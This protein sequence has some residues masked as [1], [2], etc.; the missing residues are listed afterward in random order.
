MQLTYS[1]DS[2]CA[3]LQAAAGSTKPSLGTA[4][5]QAAVQDGKRTVRVAASYP[6]AAGAAWVWCVGA[7]AWRTLKIY[8]STHNLCAAFGVV[9]CLLNPFHRDAAW[10]A[11]AGPPQVS[12]SWLSRWT[13]C[14]HLV[15]MVMHAS[16]DLDRSNTK[17]KPTISCACQL[18]VVEAAEI[19][20]HM[21][22]FPV[23]HAVVLQ[24]TLTRGPCWVD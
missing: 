16:V 20:A 1:S 18:H 15:G 19:H 10:F 2:S 7:A 12:C 21:N 17:P 9:A 11:V 14:C 8:D 5:V 24:A 13:T 22:G 6:P 4:A 23:P 3:Q